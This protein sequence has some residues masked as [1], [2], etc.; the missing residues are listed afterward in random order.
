MGLETGSGINLPE[1]L[2]TRV[3]G[4]VGTLSTPQLEAFIS[5]VSDFRRHSCDRE[6]WS[7]FGRL[8]LEA[9]LNESDPNVVW[10]LEI[11]ALAENARRTKAESEAARDRLRAQ[12]LDFGWGSNFGAK[13]V[14]DVKCPSCGMAR[15]H[16]G[17]SAVVLRGRI[18]RNEAVR[19]YCIQCDLHWDAAADEVAVIEHLLG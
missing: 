1:S 8:V 6:R 4:L 7:P 10:A 12:G 9:G 2:L 17:Y 16:D 3:G 19:L 5:A 15:R 11:A 18:D 13:L 14:F